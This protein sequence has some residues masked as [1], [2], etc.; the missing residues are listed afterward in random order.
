[1]ALDYGTRGLEVD[2]LGPDQLIEA[3]AFL[4]REPVLNVYLL[5]LLLRDALARPRD[6]MWGARRDG[7]LVAIAHLGGHSGAVL[8]VGDD[9]EAL[10]QLAAITLDRRPALPRRLQVIGPRVAVRVLARRFTEHGVRARLSRD[11]LYLV[12]MPEA[13]PALERLPELRIAGPPDYGLLYESGAHLRTEELEEDPR[14]ADA[15]SY[16]RRVADECRDGSTHLWVDDGGL[17]FRASVSAITPD[18]AQ[19][20]G[21]YTPPARRRAGLARR[22]LSELCARLYERSRAVC[23]FVNDFNRPALQL[24]AR[25]GFETRAEWASAF[26]DPD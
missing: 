11:Q 7:E 10:D 25:L 13:R 21:V 9:L 1:M 22:G 17:C 19:V 2:R 12:R 20:S 8:P 3:F 15:A 24:Y 23:L 5:A 16:A 14:L 6:E 18:A 4:D 26:F